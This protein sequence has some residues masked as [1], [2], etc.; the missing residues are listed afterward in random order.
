MA[1][2][3]QLE[4]L[5]WIAQLG[6]FSR[7][8][9]HLNASQS[10]ISKRIQEL[11]QD[12]GFAAFERGGRELRVT[13]RGA[14]LLDL[15]SDM[16][17]LAAQISELSGEGYQIQRHLRIGVNE[18]TAATWLPALISVLERDDRTMVHDV[19]VEG[20]RALT[21]RLENGHLDLIIRTKFEHGPLLRSRDIGAVP[22]SW[23]ASPSLCDRDR[24]YSPAELDSLPVVTYGIQAGVRDLVQPWAPLRR[25][26]QRRV[27]TTDSL[28]ALV[29]MAVAGLGVALVPAS[30]CAPL[31]RAGQL[32]EIRT[33]ARP[34]ELPFVVAYRTNE[35]DRFMHA[36][37]QG[38]DE[39]CDF[40]APELMGVPAK[41]IL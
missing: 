28:S 40:S 30:F 5:Y 25:S 29:R 20:A 3:R 37:L 1:T 15:A 32:I 24:L 14:E 2:L 41:A 21:D 34:T 13:P 26:R 27:I 33:D 18:L 35:E 4:A 19:E 11:E 36:V 10:A 17:A 8:A 39:A 23:I 16:L 9:E 12:C 22:L 31:V 6:S 7:A 38:V